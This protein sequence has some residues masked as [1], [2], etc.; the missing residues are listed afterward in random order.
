MHN[1]DALQVQARQ[2]LDDNNKNVEALVT[3]ILCNYNI[4]C[5][6]L[7]CDEIIDR[8]KS[9]PIIQSILNPQYE[10]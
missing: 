6:R 7:Q 10:M 2:E 1:S 5:S 8:I 9:C 3:C 4:E